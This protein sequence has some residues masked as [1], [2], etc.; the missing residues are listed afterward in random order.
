MVQRAWRSP[1]AEGDILSATAF[2]SGEGIAIPPQFGAKLGMTRMIGA[3]RL[4]IQP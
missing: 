2:P 3:E 4:R 1:L